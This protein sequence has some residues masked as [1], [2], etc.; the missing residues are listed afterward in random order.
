MR[1]V[2]SYYP[3]K[4]GEIK[5]IEKILNY[6]KISFNLSKKICD[7]VILYTNSKFKKLVEDYGI[8]YTEIN[9]EI[10]DNYSGSLD[11]YA[12][13]K[14]LTYID[15]KEPF[16]HLD[17]DTMLFKIPN[18]STD[19]FFGYFDYDLS[20]FK[21][22]KDFENLSSY[23][24]EDY[25]SISNKIPHEITNE[26]E[27]NHTPNFSLFGVNSP[28]TVSD[29]FRKILDLYME[30]EEIFNNMRHSPSQI[31]QFLFIPYLLH[32]NEGAPTYDFI[33]KESPVMCDDKLI[34]F[35]DNDSFHYKEVPEDILNSYV[36]LSLQTRDF[37]F[38]HLTDIKR[39]YQ[40]ENAFLISLKKMIFI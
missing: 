39:N 37:Y 23:Y 12:V 30:N 34:Y 28:K 32:T 21:K 20:N 22:L 24:L 16:I 27:L 31:E 5:E 19:V 6:S 33:E 3:S 40:V 4:Y 26:F 17:Y 9:T 7:N 10:F 8:E 11:N 36:E 13:P 14:I 38:L 1:I 25:R 2:Y 15:Q 29:T 35:K 18:M